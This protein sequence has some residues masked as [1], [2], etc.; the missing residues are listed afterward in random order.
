VTTTNPAA[1]SSGRTITQ[2]NRAMQSSQSPQTRVAPV[3]SGK[4]NVRA[5]RTPAQVQSRAPAASPAANG[6]ASTS[7]NQ[8]RVNKRGN[9]KDTGIQKPADNKKKDGGNRGRN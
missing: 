7:N 6:P 3:Q 4:A 8:V 1:N 5:P 2:T 9:T